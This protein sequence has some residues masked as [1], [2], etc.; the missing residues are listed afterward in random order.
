MVTPNHIHS[1][2]AIRAGATHNNSRIQHLVLN[3][4]L[5]DSIAQKALSLTPGA[6]AGASSKLLQGSG[7]DQQGT[8]A[9]RAQAA[10]SRPW[11]RAG[12]GAE[13]LSNSSKQAQLSKSYMNTGMQSAEEAHERRTEVKS[14]NTSAT[15]DD[16]GVPQPV[17]SRAVSH[18]KKLLTGKKERDNQKPHQQPQQEHEHRRQQHHHVAASSSLPQSQAKELSHE[19]VKPPNA[20]PTAA[21]MSKIRAA[22]QARMLALSGA[23]SGGKKK[24]R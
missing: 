19:A 24:R 4:S 7:T 20:A 23:A 3:T 18:L 13:Q 11:E 9:Q 12:V 22:D 5:L 16:Q 21:P 1:S 15:D 2:R 10:L 8:R 14:M 17:E 6:G